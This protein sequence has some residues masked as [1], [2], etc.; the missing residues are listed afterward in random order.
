[1]TLKKELL[2]FLCG[3]YIGS[4]HA[5]CQPHRLQLHH[6]SAIKPGSKRRQL[7]RQL[8]SEAHHSDL[9]E[10][11]KLPRTEADESAADELS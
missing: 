4:D 10:P 2:C 5:C 9:L 7:Q 6:T 11:G 3:N 1:M 8:L